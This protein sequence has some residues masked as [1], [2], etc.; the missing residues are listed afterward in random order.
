MGRPEMA[1]KHKN[2]TTQVCGLRRLRRTGVV[3]WSSSSSLVGVCTMMVAGIESQGL[4]P[5]DLKMGQN[6]PIRGF[7]GFGIFSWVLGLDPHLAP[8]TRLI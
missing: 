7:R 4:N 3:I 2:P 8:K 6:D 5:I 1:G